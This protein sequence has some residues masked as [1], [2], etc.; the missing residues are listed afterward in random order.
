MTKTTELTCALDY[1]R[2]L[3]SNK[4]PNGRV[5]TYYDTRKTHR[6]YKIACYGIHSKHLE[7]TFSKIK[8]SIV[9]ANNHKLINTF[10]IFRNFV[11]QSFLF[12]LK[13]L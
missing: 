2:T 5:V 8:S 7:I 13:N 10:S 12:F 3:V 4:H 1:I 6:R 9:F 11:K